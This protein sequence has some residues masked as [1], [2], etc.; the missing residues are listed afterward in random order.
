MH[1]RTE[2]FLHPNAGS[3]ALA[4]TGPDSYRGYIVVYLCASCLFD[5]DGRLEGPRLACL[6][7]WILNGI[8]PDYIH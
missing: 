3:M 2:I 5:K 1:Y 7:A 6:V 8:I 4:I